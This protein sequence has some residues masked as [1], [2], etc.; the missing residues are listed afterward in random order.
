LLNPRMD[1]AVLVSAYN[2]HRPNRHNNKFKFPKGKIDQGESEIS[3]ASREVFEEVGYSI[4]DK[5]NERDKIVIKNHR[6]MKK[7][8]Y[9]IVPDVPENTQF[10]TH[11]VK[12]IGAIEWFRISDIRN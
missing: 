10:Q 12:E 9:Y 5:I 11:T 2:E 6:N 8:T 4:E 1:K 7:E 3:C